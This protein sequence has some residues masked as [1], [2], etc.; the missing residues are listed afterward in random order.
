MILHLMQTS[1]TTHSIF[2][3]GLVTTAR[4]GN[5]LR[6]F[7]IYE[8]QMARDAQALIIFIDG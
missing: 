4:A 6:S 7:I 8:P 5:Q 3:Y 1:V 2:L